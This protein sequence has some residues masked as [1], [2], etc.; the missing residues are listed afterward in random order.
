VSGSVGEWD[1]I[2]AIGALAGWLAAVSATGFGETVG[3]DGTG[4]GGDP[5]GLQEVVVTAQ[6]RAESVQD[7]GIAISVLS[8][9]IDYTSDNTSPVGVSFDG[10]GYV[11][12]PLPQIEI[13]E[14]SA[15]DVAE[16]P[17]NAGR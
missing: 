8:G 10:V 14:R 2:A 3:A 11:S 17:A 16:F 1:D 15:G 12:G 4:V 13:P 7:V 6:R 5:G 9:F